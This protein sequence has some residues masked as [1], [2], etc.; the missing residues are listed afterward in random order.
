M[1]RLLVIWTLLA[2]FLAVSCVDAFVVPEME[3]NDRRID[4]FNFST[5]LVTLGTDWISAEVHDFYIS[6]TAR[7]DSITFEAGLRSQFDEEMCIAR[8][9]NYTE[10]KPVSG[11]TVQSRV[12]YMIETISSGDIAR[13]FPKGETRLGAQFRSTRQG[14]FVG[15]TTLRI[16]VFYSSD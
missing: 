16:T 9:Y 7:I 14:H 13:T 8:L 2:A 11:S 12:A 10:D 1:R 4:V 5:D 6:P 3:E 15:L